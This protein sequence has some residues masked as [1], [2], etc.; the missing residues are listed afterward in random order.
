MEH[1]EIAFRT[2]LCLQLALDTDDSHW[3]LD[4][5]L[6]QEQKFDHK[7]FLKECRKESERSSEVFITSYWEKYTEPE[8]PASWML[9]EIVPF[10]TWSR[11]YSSLQNREIQKGVSKYF[12]L[13]PFILQSWIHALTVFR[14]LCAHH[15]R[16]WNRSLTIRPKLTRNEI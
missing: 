10:G 15:A 13:P 8:L 7:K 4:P 11:L 9:I 6:F 12:G 1:I 2:Q 16:I 5:F 14:N 3:P